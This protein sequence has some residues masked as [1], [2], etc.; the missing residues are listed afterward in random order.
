MGEIED[1]LERLAAHRAAQIPE[2]S[3]PAAEEEVVVRRHATRRAPLIGA[4]AACVVVGLVIG[5]WF[6]AS[7]R[8]DPLSVQTSAGPSAAGGPAGLP[9][10]SLLD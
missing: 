6:L 9:G 1:R 10:L 8:D 5:G 7:S 4:I 3:T 2:F